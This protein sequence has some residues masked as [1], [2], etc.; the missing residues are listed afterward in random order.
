VIF[1]TTLEQLTNT[2]KTI[3]KQLSNNQQQVVNIIME[4]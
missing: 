1:A 3:L 4:S 2:F